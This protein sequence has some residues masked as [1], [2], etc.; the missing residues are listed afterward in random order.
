MGITVRVAL[1]LTLCAGCYRPCDPGK[2][3]CGP[4]QAA[5]GADLRDAACD[6]VTQAGCEGGLK[7]TFSAVNNPRA[8]A[9]AP[10]DP[11]AAGRECSRTDE[12]DDCSGGAWCD[13]PGR[14]AAVCR[15]FCE[16]DGAC[17]MMGSYCAHSRNAFR[18]CSV[19][20][21]PTSG[22][23]PT[24]M[25]CRVVKDVGTGGRLETDCLLAGSAGPREACST[26][27]DCQPGLTCRAL[28]D[29][30]PHA[31]ACFRLCKAG[32]QCSAPDMGMAT[33]KLA[34]STNRYGHCP[35]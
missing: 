15:Q 32:S 19:V 12:G 4:D 6:V 23:C 5:G 21:D 13:S 25:A 28:D 22:P 34:K 8:C 27:E 3:E 31:K 14:N 35:Y 33:C 20:C 30:A 16:D 29:L 24:Q 17:P 2:R 11:K 10:T 18:L 26:D 9:A 1:V 7:C